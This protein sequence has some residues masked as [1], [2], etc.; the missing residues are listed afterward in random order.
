MESGVAGDGFMGEITNNSCVSLSL[1]VI[2]NNCR[3]TGGELQAILD[4]EGELSE[5]QAQICMREILEALRYLHSK[6]IAH[7]DIKPQ[8]IL[9]CGEKV[10]GECLNCVILTPNYN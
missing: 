1:C 4:D 2:N 7:L 8:N 9:M 3:A 10:E 6:S 5:P